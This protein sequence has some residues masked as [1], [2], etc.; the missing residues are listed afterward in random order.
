MQLLT[1]FMDVKMNGIVMTIL[2]GNIT[3]IAES[4]FIKR[5]PMNK[6]KHAEIR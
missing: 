2:K 3:T 4:V 1:G 6:M 5:L